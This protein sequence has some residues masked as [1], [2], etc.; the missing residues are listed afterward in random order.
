MKC[1]VNDK[2]SLTS[3]SDSSWFIGEHLFLGYDL[4]LGE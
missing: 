3:H 2:N 1:N 4:F